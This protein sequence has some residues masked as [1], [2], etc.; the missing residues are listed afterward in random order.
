MRKIVKEFKNL[1]VQEINALPRDHWGDRELLDVL[2][3]FNEE[4]DEERAAATRVLILNSPDQSELVSYDELYWNQV[5]HWRGP[6]HQSIDTIQWTY[7]HLT[8]TARCK[9][10]D[11]LDSYYRDLAE[12]YL[13]FGDFNTALR[14]ATRLWEMDPSDIWI[15]NAIAFP[16]DEFGQLES[17]LQE[18][19]E[20]AAQGTDRTDEVDPDVLNNF[21]AALQL[22]P[23]ASDG[24][25][26]YL[27]PVSQ[28]ID[29]A[30]QDPQAI[31]AEISQHAKVYAHYIIAAV[32]TKWT[33]RT[34]STG[35]VARESRRTWAT[36]F[37]FDLYGESRGILHGRNSGNCREHKEQHVDSHICLRRVRRTRKTVT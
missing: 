21:R 36:S 37:I 31:Y 24:F 3:Y 18:A 22:K 15:S 20:N 5:N 13:R 33:E 7:A 9:D 34:R 2:Q 1:S 23:S 6:G 4:R 25:D 19:K 30:D 27:P 29:L 10:G 32:S 12:L 17:G 26:G 8:Y 16:L 11:D 28:L 35:S 14:L